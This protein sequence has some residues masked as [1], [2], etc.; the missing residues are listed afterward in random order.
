MCKA[1]YEQ[2]IDKRGFC[3]K[4]CIFYNICKYYVDLIEE[5]G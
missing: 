3:V 4:K 5:D 2:F 1:T